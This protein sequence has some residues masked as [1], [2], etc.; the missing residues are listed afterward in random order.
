MKYLEGFRFSTLPF[1]P[2]ADN[3]VMKAMHKHGLLPLNSTS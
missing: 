1:F 3:E 2:A